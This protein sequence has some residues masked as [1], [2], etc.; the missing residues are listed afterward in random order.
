MAAFDIATFRQQSKLF[1]LLDAKGQERLIALAREEAFA[2]GHTLMR[3]GDSGQ[4]FY[5]VL[6]GALQVLIDGNAGP[7]EVARLGPG[8]FVGEIAALMG[9]PRSATVVTVGASTVLRFDAP[10]IQDLLKEYPTVRQA[11]VKLAL[12]RS[13]NNLA[14]MI[15]DGES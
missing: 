3:E 5:V 12:K 7:R 13:E 8:A 2:D 6:Q 9:E 1:Q 11:L 4:S 14:E 15:K 10:P